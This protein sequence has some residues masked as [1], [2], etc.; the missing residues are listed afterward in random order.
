VARA[1]DRLPDLVRIQET[2]MGLLMP[3]MS[4]GQPG[5][6]TISAHEWMALLDAQAQIRR[7]W[8][9]LFEAFDVVLTPVHGAPAFPHDD[10]P[11]LG[12]RTLVINGAETPYFAP[13]AWA[14]PATLGNLPS[15]VIPVGQTRS[16][17]PFGAQVIGPYLEDRTTIGFAGLAEREFGGFRKPPGF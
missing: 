1:S 8:A 15:T 7:Q 6:Q 4:R 13:A 17:L 9:E 10:E 5:A 16:G 2:F 14:G 11:D 12:K 3:A